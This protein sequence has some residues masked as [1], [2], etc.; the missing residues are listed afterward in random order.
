MHSRGGTRTH[1]PGIMSSGGQSEQKTKLWLQHTTTRRDAPRRY[2]VFSAKDGASD[3]PRNAP[4]ALDKNTRNVSTRRQQQRDRRYE[5]REGLQALTTEPRVAKCG[6]CR[7]A[8]KVEVRLAGGGA[9]YSGVMTCGS[10]WLCP[11]CAQKVAARRREEVK[12]VLTAHRESGGGAEFLTL[13]LP[14]TAGDRLARTRRL[15][16]DGWKRVQQGRVWKRLKATAGVVGTI[17]VLEVTFGFANGWHPHIQVIV[18][19]Q[20]PLTD[21]ERAALRQH[22]FGVWQQAVVNAGHATPLP[23]CTTIVPVVNADIGA[24]ATKFGAG[25]ELANGNGDANARL[26]PFQVLAA[27]LDTGE[28][29]YLTVWQEWESGIKGAKQLTWSHGLRAHYAL[30]AVHDHHASSESVGETVAII[31]ADKWRVIVARGMRLLVLET[32]ERGG[33]TALSA[34]L[35]ALPDWRVPAR[36]CRASRTRTRSYD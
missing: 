27:F 30:P 18:L 24:Y 33:A 26:T 32:A 35:D 20:R 34:L 2:A 12:Q 10:V 3:E 25:C 36:L 19:T 9:H 1:D 11:V 5:L 7:I 16:A 28:D 22:C 21:E 29:R 6:K 13:T 17:R 4:A 8:P 31:D 14:H 15:V 23:Q